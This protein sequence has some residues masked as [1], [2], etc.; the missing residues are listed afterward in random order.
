MHAQGTPK[1]FSNPASLMLAV[2]M[3][4]ASIIKPLV[5]EPERALSAPRRQL[6]TR[7]QPVRPA[8]FAARLLKGSLSAK[9]MDFDTRRRQLIY[10]LLR[11]SQLTF[12]SLGGVM[13][14]LTKHTPLAMSHPPS[15]P[16]SPSELLQAFCNPVVVGHGATLNHRASTRNTHPQALNVPLLH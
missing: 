3:T 6:E 11:G 16:G 2:L 4:D 10:E 12:L 14:A 7:Q 9:C 5:T 1:R 15:S 13:V 8:L